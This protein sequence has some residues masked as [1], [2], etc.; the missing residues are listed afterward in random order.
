M[1][2][3]SSKSKDFVRKNTTVGKKIWISECKTRENSALDSRLVKATQLLHEYFK[4]RKTAKKD[5]VAPTIKRHFR[6]LKINGET[7]THTEALQ[8]WAGFTVEEF[9]EF[10]KF[11]KTKNA[12]FEEVQKWIRDQKPL[13]F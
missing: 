2:K 1:L 12:T 9:E 5:F 7:K 3:N 11:F 6:K 13:D 10:I 4:L 8:T